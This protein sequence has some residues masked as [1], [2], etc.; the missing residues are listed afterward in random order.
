[1]I[2][3]QYKIRK[4]KEKTEKLSFDHNKCD[5]KNTVIKPIKKNL[6]KKIILEY[7]WLK[8]IP[9]ITRYHFGIYFNIDRKE[10]L[11]GV[12]IF[13]DDYAQNTGVWDKK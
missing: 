12:L 6:A 3:H 2:A 9:L 11:G 8:T 4:E 10:Y 13:S 1:M 7:E 5:L